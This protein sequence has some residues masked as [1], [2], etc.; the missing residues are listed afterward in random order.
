MI[1]IATYAIFCYAML[2]DKLQDL[3]PVSYLTA[4]FW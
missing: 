2:H 4:Y 3:S 1:Q